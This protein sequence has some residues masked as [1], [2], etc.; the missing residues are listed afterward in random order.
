M[1]TYEMVFTIVHLC[2]IL[3]GFYCIN[4]ILTPRP[5]VSNAYLCSLTVLLVSPCYE[6]FTGDVRSLIR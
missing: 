3:C 1:L 2:D 6:I 4:R 5:Q